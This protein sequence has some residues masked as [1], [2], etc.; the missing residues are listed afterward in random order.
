MVDRVIIDDK[1]PKDF[2]WVTA[3]IEFSIQESFSSLLA[4]FDHDLKIYQES[5]HRK[6]NITAE[7]RT[8]ELYVR[9]S[10][11]A[12]RFKSPPIIA[13]L[14]AMTPNRDGIQLDMSVFNQTTKEYETKTTAITTCVTDYGMYG[15]MMD[16]EGPLYA[17]QVSRRAL[18]TLLFGDA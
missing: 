7:K 4:A 9:I 17:W 12:L 18:Q 11:N 2:D 5:E 3:V 6:W 8:N 14:L 16:G 1:A 15:F 10:E 13:V